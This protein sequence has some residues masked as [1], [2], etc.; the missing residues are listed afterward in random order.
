MEARRRPRSRSEK[1]DGPLCPVC[2]GSGASWTG[3]TLLQWSLEDASFCLLHCHTF[4]NEEGEG[5]SLLSCSI[6][7]PPEFPS[8]TDTSQKQHYG[9]INQRPFSG[10]K[11]TQHQQPRGLALSFPGR[12]PSR[13]PSTRMSWRWGRGLENCSL[14]L[15]C[16]PGFPQQYL[17]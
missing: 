16:F 15:C 11:S 4:T 7:V 6:P 13:V 14:C 2:R 1:S 5:S 3:A 12:F 10:L 17:H 9:H 8:T